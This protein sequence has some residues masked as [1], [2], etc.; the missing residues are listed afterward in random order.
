MAN[1]TPTPKAPVSMLYGCLFTAGTQSDLL[2]ARTGTP[3]PR[4]DPTR[5]T[6][7]VTPSTA[8]STRAPPAPLLLTALATRTSSKM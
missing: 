6:C 4:T 1:A 8:R 3:H 2:E 5:H 7:P